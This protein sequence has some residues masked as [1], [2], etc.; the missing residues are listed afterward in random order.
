V[1]YAGQRVVVFWF[2]DKGL[3]PFILPGG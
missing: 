1:G 2:V 3:F